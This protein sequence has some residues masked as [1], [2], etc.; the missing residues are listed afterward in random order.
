MNILSM[1]AGKRTVLSD[2]ATPTVIGVSMQSTG[3]AI[4]SVTLGQGRDARHPRRR[5]TGIERL[6]FDVARVHD[7]I[8]GIDLGPHDL[9]VIDAAGAG[10]ALW[11]ALDVRNGRHF[12]LYSASGRARQTLVD[13][14]PGLMIDGSFTF[15]SGLAHQDAMTKALR[16]YRREVTDDGIVGNELAIGLFLALTDRPSAPR[17]W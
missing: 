1:V 9:V 15:A 2:T 7:R 13:R 16:D 17:V 5:C 10:S 8:R 12:A 14:L 6:P 4:V 11:H 3:S